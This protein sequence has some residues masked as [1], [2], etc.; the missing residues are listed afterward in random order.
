MD[1]VTRFQDI[2]NECQKLRA[3]HGDDY[4]DACKDKIEEFSKE[5]IENDL[6]NKVHNP[7]FARQLCIV[8]EL[9][10]K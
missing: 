7:Y 5:I 1:D 9:E 3:K 8:N 2:I 4:E 10:W 6:T